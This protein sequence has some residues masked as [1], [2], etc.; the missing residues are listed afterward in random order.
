MQYFEKNITN[1]CTATGFPPLRGSKPARE[2]GV[3]CLAPVLL[4]L[5]FGRG[6]SVVF[7]Q[8]TA[9][10]LATV[11]AANSVFGSRGYSA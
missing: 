7:G 5:V 10:S 1:G 3:K 2:P 9:V 4:G 11:L 6:L 8:N